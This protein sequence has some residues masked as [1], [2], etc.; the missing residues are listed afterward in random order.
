MKKEPLEIDDDLRRDMFASDAL[1]GMLSGNRM[2]PIPED[3]TSYT[4]RA[5]AAYKHADAMM[6]ARKEKEV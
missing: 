5:K 3:P 1:C 2:Q 4:K 6:E